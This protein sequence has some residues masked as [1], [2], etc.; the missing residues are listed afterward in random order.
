VFACLLVV[1]FFVVYFAYPETRR[2]S[3]EEVATLFD[4]EDVMREMDAKIM[5]EKQD[6]L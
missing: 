1:W 6:Q 5:S 2:L 3:L 4:G